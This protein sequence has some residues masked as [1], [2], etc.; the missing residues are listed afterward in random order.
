MNPLDDREK[1]RAFAMRHA[2]THPSLCLSPSPGA[3]PLTRSHASGSFWAD[4]IC[5][6]LA[7][8]SSSPTG[9]T[10]GP[11]LQRPR[12][13]ATAARARIRAPSASSRSR[14]LLTTAAR[15][16]LAGTST[17]GAARGERV[18]PTAY[19]SG[20][21]A[22]A[23]GTTA[24]LCA[25]LRGRLRE[26]S[27]ARESAC[28]CARVA[29]CAAIGAARCRRCCCAAAR[30]TRPGRPRLTRVVCR[31][32]AGPSAVAA[33]PPGADPA[34]RGGRGMARNRRNR[35]RTHAPAV[36]AARPDCGSVGAVRAPRAAR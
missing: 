32:V 30:T 23:I 22:A 36:R 35:R 31:A 4:D 3:L 34:G 11:P 26:V 21:V 1:V 24:D 13:C 33:L 7:S 9:V 8:P 25:A 2:C 12:R 19:V 28:A 15:C 14:L 16:A 17:R 5:L 6:W 10:M 18:A 29:T 27:G 20:V